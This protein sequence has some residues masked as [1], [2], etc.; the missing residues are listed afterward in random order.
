MNI[1]IKLAQR[2][3]LQ[4]IIAMLADDDLGSRREQF[5][6]PLPTAYEMAFDAIQCNPNAHLIV[7]KKNTHVIAVAQIACVVT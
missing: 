7:V 1:E 4:A 5:I 6:R 2:S 3:D